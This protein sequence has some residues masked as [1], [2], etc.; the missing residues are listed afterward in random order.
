MSAWK[1]ECKGVTIYRDG[2]RSE[3]AI[4]FTKQG[5]NDS[6]NNNTTTCEVCDA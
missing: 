4:E 3:Q 1:L 2:S 5:A 6:S